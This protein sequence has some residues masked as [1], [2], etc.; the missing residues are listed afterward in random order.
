[1][2]LA[3]L[4]AI[5]WTD[6]DD[7]LHWSAAPFMTMV[8]SP[9]RSRVGVV[10]ILIHAAHCGGA[11]HHACATA[12]FRAHHRSRARLLWWGLLSSDWQRQQEKRKPGCHCGNA[13]L[14][15]LFQKGVYSV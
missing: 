15:P 1:M 11:R 4:Y 12:P 6:I 5:V 2:S 8:P 9:H 10:I 13:H 7:D 3:G 14:V